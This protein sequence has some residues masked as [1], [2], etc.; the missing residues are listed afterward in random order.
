LFAG[1]PWAGSQIPIDVTDEKS[2]VAAVVRL[3]NH[4][5]DA[6]KIV[7]DSGPFIPGNPK[8][9]RLPPDLLRVIIEKTH[10]LKRRATVHTWREDEAIVA[11]DAKTDG[12]EHGV[13]EALLTGPRLGELLRKNKAFYVPTLSVYEE[14]RDL[15]GPAAL[16]NGQ[17]NLKTL[18]DQG[19][20][21]ALGT[22]VFGN[23]KH[24]A[25]TIREIELM[26]VA[27]LSPAQI[28]RAATCDAAAHLGVSDQLGTVEK[29]KY[30][31]L[32]MVKDDPLKDVA[33]FKTVRVVI[34]GGKVVHEAAGN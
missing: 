24:G 25:R 11:A 34:R 3:A 21:I 18:S 28:I 19:V 2:A 5:V 6:V 9:N 23:G 32:I 15:L 7:Y 26:A 16:A 30:A 4:H 14:Y 13:A 10:E 20:Q 27:G 33:A 1:S 31:D 8:F 22:D 29:G 12:L 17:R